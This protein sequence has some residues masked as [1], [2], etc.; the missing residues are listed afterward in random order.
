DNEIVV[1]GRNDTKE[2]VRRSISAGE[3]KKIPGLNGDA[4]KVVQAL[5]GV[6]RAEFGAGAVRIRGAPTWDSRFYFD[7]VQIPLLYHFGGIKSIISSDALSSIDV[8]PGGAG[9]KYGNSI[10]GSIE[11][12]GRSAD[13]KRVQ[14]FADISLFDVTLQAEG[15]VGTKGSILAFARRSYIGDILGYMTRSGTLDLPFTTVPYYYDYNV[16]ADINISPSQNLFFTLLGS[17]DELSLI[18]PA[19][20]GGSP[21]VD[22]MIDRMKQM[23]GFNMVIIGWNK[24]F[25]PNFKNS[26][27]ASIVHGVGYG[28][29]FGFAKWD[30]NYWQY[31]LR[32]EAVWR[33]LDNISITKLQA[34]YDYS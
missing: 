33:L 17:K 1:Y 31:S 3:V 34:G 10:A 27:R 32:N 26:L 8:Y 22:D 21:S 30:M 23:L 16:R 13:T 20:S 5:P 18:A 9:V 19:V 11:I 24:E 25:S 14:G 7:G 28:T 6:G 15:P 2:V 29:Y 4:I 12:T